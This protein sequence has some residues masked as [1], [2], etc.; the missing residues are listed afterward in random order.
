MEVFHMVAQRFC[1]GEP[2]EEAP[3]YLGF[4]PMDSAGAG[5]GRIRAPPLAIFAGKSWTSRVDQWLM[6]NGG[7]SYHFQVPNPND[8]MCQYLYIHSFLNE[9]VK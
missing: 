3:R 1:S 6:T 7:F 5:V 2:L 9:S 4:L 8:S